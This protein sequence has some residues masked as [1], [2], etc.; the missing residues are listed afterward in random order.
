MS[1]IL[2][3]KN[4]TKAQKKKDQISKWYQ[5]GRGK[6]WETAERKWKRTGFRVLNWGAHEA[7]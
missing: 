4:V 2:S 7:L 3:V 5:E 1:N 6:G